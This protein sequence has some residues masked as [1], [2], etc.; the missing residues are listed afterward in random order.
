[1]GIKAVI[2]DVDGTMLDT[3]QL[4]AEAFGEA[5]KSLGY[6]SPNVDIVDW[7]NKNC[8]G[9]GSRWAFK[10]LHTIV[11]VKDDFNLQYVREFRAEWLKTQHIPTKKGLMESLEYLKKEKVKMAVCSS[12]W[13]NRVTAKLSQAGVPLDYFEVI[14]GMDLCKNPKPDAECYFLTCKKLGVKPEEAIALEDSDS[15]ALAAIDAGVK[16]VLVPDIAKNSEDVRKRA[17]RIAGSL[18]DATAIIKQELIR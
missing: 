14:V 2:F 9:R 1:M 8:S 11:D 4:N 7:Y 5:F 12:D 17:W 6:E 13:T 18:D 16:L 15:G 3:E 10:I